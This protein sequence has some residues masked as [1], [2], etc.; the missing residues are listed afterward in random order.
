MQ[1]TESS[2]ESRANLVQAPSVEWA[3][4]PP[5]LPGSHALNEELAVALADASRALGLLDGVGRML[6]NATLLTRPLARREAVLSSRIEGTQA[7]LSQLS[8]FEADGSGSESSDVR[9]VKN[10]LDALDFGLAADR[11]LP[12]SLRLIRRMHAILTR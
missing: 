2:E 5:D 3:F 1:P 6:P 11:P 8:L 4:V 7:T 9:E 12:I 10:Y